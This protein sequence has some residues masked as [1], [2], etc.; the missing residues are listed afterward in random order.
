MVDIGIGKSVFD[1]GVLRVEFG[2]DVGFRNAG[3][4]MREVV[5]LETKGTDPN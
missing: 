1:R 4:V 5:T 3:E 2:R